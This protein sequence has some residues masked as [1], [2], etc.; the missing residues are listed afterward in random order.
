MTGHRAQR[1]NKQLALKHNFILTTVQLHNTS[2]VSL[3]VSEI[4]L[5]LVIKSMTYVSFIIIV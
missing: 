4:M 3:E 5:V 1:F 2:T